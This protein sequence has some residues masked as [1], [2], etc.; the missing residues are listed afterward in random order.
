MHP[1][2]EIVRMYRRSDC[3]STRPDDQNTLTHQSADTNDAPRD[4][5]HGPVT[6]NPAHTR[7]YSTLRLR[8]SLKSIT[9]TASMALLC[10]EPTNCC[11]RYPMLARSS[12]SA[13]PCWQPFPTGFDSPVFDLIRLTWIFVR[14]NS[15]VFYLTRLACFFI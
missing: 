6:W 4:P 10:Q 12:A 1:D 11:I 9:I 2:I 8:L 15:P 5:L 7:P 3:L 14:F 13:V